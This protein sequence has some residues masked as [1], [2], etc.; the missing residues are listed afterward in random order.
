MKFLEA[1]RTAWASL[2]SN[3]LRSALTLL[4]MVIGV[5]AII[6]SVTAVKVIDVYFQESLSMMGSST[7]SV[8]RYPSITIGDRTDEYRRPITYEQ[9]ERLTEALTLPLT[10][11]PEE[12]FD[13]VTVRYGTRETEPN[14]IL[15]GSNEN[16]PL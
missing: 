7:F 13:M 8:T 10:V 2:Q 12:W 3:R 9:V 1:F 6:A 15:G 4:G 14:I 16:Y 5:F 11:S